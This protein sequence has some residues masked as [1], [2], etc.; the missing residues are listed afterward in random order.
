MQ[1][2]VKLLQQ[3]AIITNS[4]SRIVARPTLYYYYY[5]YYKIQA[6]LHQ[7][8]VGAVYLHNREAHVSRVNGWNSLPL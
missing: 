6:C 8:L 4:L 1:P 2:F 5:Y 3:L 7:V